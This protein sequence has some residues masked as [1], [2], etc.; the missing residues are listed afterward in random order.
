MGKTK[1][2]GSKEVREL[3]KWAEDELGYVA[4]RTGGGHIRFLHDDV[5][6]P[7]FC[8]SSPSDYRSLR[9][10]EALLIASLA[11]RTVAEFKKDPLNV[12]EFPKSASFF[13]PACRNRG[14]EKLFSHPQGLAAHMSKEHPAM[15]LE[16]EP[17]PQSEAVPSERAEEEQHVQVDEAPKKRY[18]HTHEL[19][20]TL[21]SSLRVGDLKDGDRITLEDIRSMFPEY[22]QHVNAITALR[23]RDGGAWLRLRSVP[24]TRGVYVVVAPDDFFDEEEQDVDLSPPWEEEISQGFEQARI[25]EEINRFVDGRL[26]LR[27]SEGHLYQ[28]EIER[29]S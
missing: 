25:F 15:P 18:L 19:E 1:L 20:Q 9:N 11:E 23:L 2:S 7:I 5:E 26:L 3:V 21:T 6:K 27:D 8:P 12:P 16:H 28:A 24:S 22:D 14:V 13:C 10:T 29:L 17:E 4:E